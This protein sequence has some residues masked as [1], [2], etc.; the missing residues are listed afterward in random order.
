MMEQRTPH[1]EGSVATPDGK[2]TGDVAL[3]PRRL[4]PLTMVQ[5]VI[6]SL[7]ALF[8]ILLPVF[9]GQDSMAV[10]NLVMG[11]M[12]LA[13][14]VPWITLHYLRFRYWITPQELV[15]HSGVLT[16]RRR[17]IPVERIQNIEIEQAPLQRL[18]GTAKVIVY[19]AGSASAEGTLEYVSV[20]EARD[21]RAVVREMQ[22]RMD[23]AESIPVADTGEKTGEETGEETGASVASARTQ[24]QTLMHMSPRR[25]L[26]AG[27]FRFSLLY[28][29]VMFSFLQ[30]IEPDPTLLFSWLM[31]GPLEPL[32]AQV[33]ASP[34]LAA[35]AGVLGAIL[36][37]WLT[38]IATTFNR[39]HR[40]RLEMIGDKLHRSHGLMTL[41]E[42]TIPLGRVQA[43]I[44]RTNPVME[45]FGWYR[46]EL[47]TMGINV[48][49]SG[50]QVAIPFGRMTEI[51][52][53]F[54]AIGAPEI[55]R[56]WHRVSPLTMRRFMARSLAAL[57]VIIGITQIWWS[58]IWWLAMAIPPLALW[59]WWRY[60]G[61]QWGEQESWIALRSGVIRRNRW[62]IPVGKIQ[63]A[64]WEATW[65]QRRL[66]LASI[67]V[68]TAGAAAIQSSGLPDVEA[69]I[70]RGLVERT[71]ARFQ[72]TA[73]GLGLAPVPESGQDADSDAVSAAG[74]PADTP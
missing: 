10:F 11:A 69:G 4:H 60:K 18:L 24:G 62:L 8:F 13:F 22:Q 14:I 52:A 41:K 71:Y 28:I 53:V 74:F 1:I 2:E 45:R 15:I 29:A 64:G 44:I 51:E 3:E 26:M 63:T 57:G 7:P 58:G 65:F 27:A 19:T 67:V 61:M 38:G 36:L 39:F 5:R 43:Y 6:V 34:I 49:E 25:V 70:V 16:R 56:E 47:Q 40:F 46:L 72:A 23:I 35:I 9:R 17:N 37:G 55:P 48:N 32:E 66:G 21:V 68:D 30:Y 33:E 50:F 42:G 73:P 59:S 54:E 12:Y 31:R 20:E